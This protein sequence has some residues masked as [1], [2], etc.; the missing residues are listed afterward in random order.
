[1]IATDFL[2]DEKK[3]KINEATR[4]SLWEVGPGPYV[5]TFE[6]L[7]TATVLALGWFGVTVIILLVSV[8]YL[9]PKFDDYDTAA[10]ISTIVYFVAIAALPT[11]IRRIPP[12]FTHRFSSIARVISLVVVRS[13]P[14]VLAGII[15][16]VIWILMKGT[17]GIK[18]VEKDLR[19]TSLLPLI[20]IVVS[21]IGFYLQFLGIVLGD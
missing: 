4:H 12:R 11:I 13:V 17:A 7:I 3:K 10:W 8:T 14:S 2:N 16:L 18:N 6:D 1:M 9:G 5:R 20:G 19:P 21:L 15:G